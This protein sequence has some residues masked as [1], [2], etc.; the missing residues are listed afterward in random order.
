MET[1]THGRLTSNMHRTPGKPL[2]PDHRDTLPFGEP[3]ARSNH[4][5][6]RDAYAVKNN[7]VYPRSTVEICSAGSE[8]QT[9]T[10]PANA[11]TCA[12]RANSVTREPLDLRDRYTALP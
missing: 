3:L 5:T 11:F 6:Y 7:S 8:S 4:S 10:A 2:A 9:N 12:R 1:V